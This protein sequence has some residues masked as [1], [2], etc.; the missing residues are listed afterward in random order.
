ME[1]GILYIVATPI[2]NLDDISKRALNTIEQAD[3]VAAEDTRHTLKLLNHFG[4]KKKLISFHEH[5]RASRFEE[6]IA[7]LKEGKLVALVSD[8]GTP[9]ISDPGT[10]LVAQCT[11]EGIRCISI[12]GACA[13]ITAL[14]LSGFLNKTFS[15]YGFLNT[16]S[17]ARKKELEEIKQ[18][19]MVAVLYES[20]NRIIKLLADI[21]E[22]M[23]GELQICIAREL[24]KIH[25]EV[26]HGSAAALYEQ[27]SKRESIKG[28]IVVVLDAPVKKEVQDS[29]IIEALQECAVEGMSKKDAAAYVASRLNIPKN[30]VYKLNM[31]LKDE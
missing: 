20:P 29:E 30:K 14:T 15:F 28:E 26:L 13:A 18:K 8:A 24:T 1:Y 19:D 7:Y 5:S 25:E 23:G 16:K 21:V 6:I 3:L 10:E 9:I 12:P 27:L 2:G 31:S 11:K 22:V 17:A 4:L